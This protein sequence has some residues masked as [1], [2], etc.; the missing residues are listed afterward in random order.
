MSASICCRTLSYANYR[1]LRKGKTTL[2]IMRE[3][4]EVVV[5][6]RA[7]AGQS[8]VFFSA[9]VAINLVAVAPRL[10]RDRDLARGQHFDELVYRGGKFAPTLVD[11]RE[12]SQERT[13]VEFEQ[14]ERTP[15]RFV[16]D[17]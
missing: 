6:I 5:L 7:E 9:F 1:S 10:A 2:A 13:F 15:D 12:R 17:R 11:D 16:F 3:V 8:G 14:L 4:R